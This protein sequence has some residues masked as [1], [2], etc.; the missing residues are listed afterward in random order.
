MSV[1]LVSTTIMTRL[2]RDMDV[3]NPPKLLHKA[4]PEL[5]APGRKLQ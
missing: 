1:M 2:G 3:F 5:Q 4:S